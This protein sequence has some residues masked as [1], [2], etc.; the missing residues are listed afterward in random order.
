MPMAIA[1]LT[2]DVEIYAFTKGR[3]SLLHPI[4]TNEKKKPMSELRK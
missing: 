1:G 4:Q 2:P 3:S